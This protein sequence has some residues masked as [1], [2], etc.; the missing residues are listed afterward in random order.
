MEARAL[1]PYIVNEAWLEI[2][3]EKMKNIRENVD[4]KVFP[5]ISTNR[6]N[7]RDYLKSAYPAFTELLDTFQKNIPKE[8]FDGNARLLK[9]TGKII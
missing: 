1:F 6:R 9:K 4:E 2:G 3:S 5:Y 8:I 7:N